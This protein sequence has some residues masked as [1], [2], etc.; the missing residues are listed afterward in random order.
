M[1]D[2]P[3]LGPIGQI[4]RTVGDIAAARHFYDEL[5]GLPLLYEFPGMAF[6]DLG[7]TRLY[8]QEGEAGRS[9]SILY[10]RVAD[11]AASHAHLERKGVKFL[12]PPHCVHRHADGLEEW[13]AFFADPEDRPLALMAQQRPA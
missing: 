9:E 3:G 8:L 5:L 11:I 13:L 6:F 4:A 10:F 12:Q 2:A 1:T 7:G